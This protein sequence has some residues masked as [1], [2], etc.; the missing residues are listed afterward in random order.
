VV[1]QPF[2]VDT[3]AHGSQLSCDEACETGR[4]KALPATCSSSEEMVEAYLARLG[5]SHPMAPT[6]EFLQG[7][8]RAHAQTIPYENLAVLAGKPVSLDA[9]DLF[10]KIITERRGGYCFELNSLFGW[11]LQQLGYEVEFRMGRVW[12]RDPDAVPPRNHGTN[13]VHVAGRSVIADVGFGGRAPRRP[14]DLAERDTSIDDGDALGEPL[15]IVDAGEY[16]DMVQRFIAGRWSNQ[17]SLEPIAAHASDLEIANY[18]Q[19]NA[20]AS[21]FRDHLFVGLFREDGRDGLFNTRLSRRRGTA[22]VI[23][24]LATIDQLAAA[25]DAVFR[26]DPGEHRPVLARIVEQRARG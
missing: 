23:E 2:N 18:Y 6:L 14:L 15:R 20:P 19:S 21:Q 7:L 3:Q 12:L 1:Q 16:G 9:P 17:F 24:D 5:L 10:R 13:V 8:Q 26:I 11:L 4:E 25:L 22:T